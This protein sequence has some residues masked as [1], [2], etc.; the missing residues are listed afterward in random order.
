MD[1]DR[2]GSDHWPIH[3]KYLKNTP[4]PCV[5]RWKPCEADWGA[6]TNATTVDREAR[7]FLD[8][9][10]A[11][12]YLV[13][14]LICGAMSSIP[15]TTGLPRRP[16][17]PWWNN[18][19]AASR[20]ATRSCHKRYC[21]MPIL[22]N[23]IVYRKA[24]ASQ[25][26]VFKQARRESFISY[27][28]ELNS[29]S[30]LSLVWNRIRKLQGKFVPSPLPI[31]KVNG[32]LLS[33]ACEVAEA[34]ARH[35][36]NVSS[37]SHYSTTFQRIRERTLVVPPYSTNMEAY[38]VPF[39]EDELDYALTMSS[40]TS[41]G[42]DDILYSML[43]NMPLTSKRFLLEV[44]NRFWCTGTSPVSWKTSVIVTI[45]KPGKDAHLAQSYRPIALTSCVSKVYE[46]MVNARLVWIL[47]SRN[48]LSNRQFG[49]RK[50]RST[51]DPLLL[52]TRE[53]QNSFAIQ[54]Q[55]IAVFFDIEKAYDTTWQGGILKQLA[56]WGIGGNMFACLKD[57]LSDRWLKV[58]VG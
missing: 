25:K 37:V 29:D 19:C 58:R 48:L 10:A 27:I 35:F 44:L 8:T 56:E 2:H 3:I 12:E 21:R 23:L 43:S 46:R 14:I 22:I 47:E 50:A 18:D 7:D 42:G 6:F 54:N 38:N 26:K 45:L 5:P 55:T 30:P 16:L 36:S 39:A 33:D 40:P 53:V 32:L 17:V 9:S 28:T 15:K 57:F 24:L 49:F 4:S 11:Y 51:I 34:F 31:L 13:G 20:S 52:L 41:P 1:E